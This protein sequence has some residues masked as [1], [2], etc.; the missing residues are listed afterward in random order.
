MI[1]VGVLRGGPSAEHKV[2]LKTGESVLSS[3]S[4]KYEGNDIFLSSEGDWFL[5]G[6]ISHPE[7]VFR[8]V[9]VVFNALRGQFGEDGKVQQILETFKVPYTG[10]GVLASAIGMN[11][12]LAREAFSSVGLLV[13]RAV[14]VGEDEDIEEAALRIFRTMGPS[15]AVKPFLSGSSM[16]VSIVHNYPDLIRAI[17]KASLGEAE[18][19]GY[20]LGKVMVEEYIKGR[21]ATCGVIEDFRDEKYYAPPVVEIIPPDGSDFF[22][23]KAKSGGLANEI[24]PANFS[25]SEKIKIENIAREAHKAVGCRHYSRSD[26]I[27]S[28]RG[29]YILELN[30]SPELEKE[31]LFRK[32]I[33]A[34]GVSYSDFL[35]HLIEK[36]IGGH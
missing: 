30:T 7:Q 21:E 26:F 32:S 29:I 10:S 11:K 27:V 19:P 24:C 6:K 12:M 36:A 20:G 23:Y 2:S 14:T 13:P 9:D 4:E 31:S 17:K 22:D 3:L 34:A 5:N 35:A 28:P 1:K 15:L 8:S 16:G 18:N 25:E 33:D